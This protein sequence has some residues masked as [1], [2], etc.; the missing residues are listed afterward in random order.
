[1]KKKTLGQI[2]FEFVSIVFAV[3]LALGL[4]TYKNSIDLENESNNVRQ[5]II[6]EFKINLQR[7]DSVIVNNTVYSNYL[8][9]LVNLP[10]EEVQSFYFNYEFELLPQSAWDIA[11]NSNATNLI[12]TQFLL[13]AA[14]IYHQQEFLEGFAGNVFENIGNA[15]MRKNELQEYNLA[16]SVYFNVSLMNDVSNN[17]KNDYLEFLEKYD[18]S[19][20]KD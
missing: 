11:Q 8:D 7:V 18:T 1:M 5:N 2:A 16:L 20:T 12:E 13:D 17:L 6:S 3:L 15:I 19:S 14:D 4:S 10:A 9:S